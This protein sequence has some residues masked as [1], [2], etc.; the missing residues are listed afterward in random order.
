MSES[1][2]DFAGAAY[3]FSYYCKASIIA[4][5]AKP[6][7]FAIFPSFP[8]KITELFKI[9]KTLLYWS[10]QLAGWGLLGVYTILMAPAEE[11]SEAHVALDTFFTLSGLMLL[12]H[13]YRYSIIRWGWL[14]MLFAKLILRI[15]LASFVL[16]VASTPIALLSTWLFRHQDFADSLQADRIQI[17]IITATLIYFG[18]S[19]CYF[20]YHYVTNYNRNLKWE[21]LINEFELNRLKSQLNPHFIF[22]ALNTVRA[23]VDEE[24][25]KAKSSINQLSNIL[26]NSLMMDKQKVTPFQKEMDI[27][28]DYLALEGTRFEERLQVSYALAEQANPFKVPPM[29][30]QTIV[31]NAIKHGISKKIDGGFIHIE[32]NVADDKLHIA[33]RNTGQYRPSEKRKEGYGLKSTRQRLALLYR[34]AASFQIENDTADTVLVNLTIPRWDESLL[35]SN[36]NGQR[37]LDVQ[38]N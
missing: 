29:M 34:D 33:I 7:F 30:L 8:M 6:L 11:S 32:A 37:Q 35:V 4:T 25:E 15:M 1:T 26:R 17:N 2:P 9:N 16:A 31:E 36:P 21:A 5:G 27:V 24:P 38:L 20:L 10:C 14:K 13:G 19:L 28:R 18:W 3:F 23:L 12:S 22:N